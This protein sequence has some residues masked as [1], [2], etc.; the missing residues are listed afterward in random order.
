VGR[1]ESPDRIR[2]HPDFHPYNSVAARQENAIAIDSVE[3][4]AA[5]SLGIRGAF[6]D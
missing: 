4:P 3:G 6:L 1:G 5:A 2:V